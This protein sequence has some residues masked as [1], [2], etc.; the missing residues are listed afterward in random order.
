MSFFRRRRRL[1]AWPTQTDNELAERYSTAILAWEA[2]HG[3]LR[4]DYTAAQ[5]Q[6]LQIH[7]RVMD[8]GLSLRRLLYARWLVQA[9]RCSDG[10]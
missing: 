5:W 7:V 8:S 2:D 9:G 10:E 4:E 1:T 6:R 3:T